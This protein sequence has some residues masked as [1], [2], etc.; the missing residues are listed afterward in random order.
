MSRLSIFGLSLHPGPKVPTDD[1]PSNR[2]QPKAINSSTGPSSPG[3][4]RGGSV[5]MQG[6]KR[7]LE[8][9]ASTV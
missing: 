4:H 8:S 3:L 1:D 6:S 9:F 5:F 7:G 2:G